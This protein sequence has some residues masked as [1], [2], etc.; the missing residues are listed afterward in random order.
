MG[1][2]HGSSSAGGPLTL[3]LFHE[4]RGNSHHHSPHPHWL[5]NVLQR[6]LAQVLI[7]QSQLVLDL[8]INHLRDAYPPCF[9]YS[10]QPYR[11]I[12]PISMDLLSFHH[13]LSEIDPHAKFDSP[14]DRQRGIA[15]LELVLH[16]NGTLHGFHY[17]GELR[18]Q[19]VSSRAR[20]AAA[21]LPDQG[22]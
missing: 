17:T 4:G 3:V 11:D 18:Q 5:G 12:D 2:C 9:G 16:L 21:V 14:G 22:A 6:V 15:A 7:L 8:L 1:G 10:L 19:A 13:N 20:D